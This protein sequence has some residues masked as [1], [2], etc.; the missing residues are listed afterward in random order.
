MCG[1]LSPWSPSRTGS[2]ASRLASSRSA[3]HSFQA[4]DAAGFERTARR[5]LRPLELKE[6]VRHVAKALRRHLDDEYPVALRQITATL[7]APLEGT[8]EVSSGLFIEWPLLQIVEDHGADEGV[9]LEEHFE[10]SMAALHALT[11][12]FSAEFAV[13]PFLAPSSRAHPFG[14]RAVRGRQ[15]CARAAP[16][17]VRGHGLVCPGAYA[18]SSSSTSRGAPGRSLGLLVDDEELYVRRSVANHVN[19]LSKDHPELAV[20]LSER[21]LAKKHL[22]RV[23]RERRTWVVKHALRGLVKKG[24]P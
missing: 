17:P 12:R 23:K 3:L 9:D 8:E 16:L 1:I 15:Q 5:G 14:A 7:E 6:R 24:H 21:W 13:R 10:A 20:E 2:T 4:S 18:F 11:Q 22:S 19:D